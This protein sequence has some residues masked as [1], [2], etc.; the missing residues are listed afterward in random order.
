MTTEG[1]DRQPTMHPSACCRSRRKDWRFAALLGFVAGLGLA[2]LAV[3]FITGCGA[4]EAAP[5]PGPGDEPAIECVWKETTWY[6]WIED[7]PATTA[8]GFPVYKNSDVWPMRELFWEFGCIDPG[9]RGFDPWG[10]MPYLIQ[11]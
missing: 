9:N 7:W 1:F 4:A 11:R 5:G 2:G 10:A 6:V 8:E 3:M